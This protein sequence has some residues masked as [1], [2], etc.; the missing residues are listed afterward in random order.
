MENLLYSDENLRDMSGPE[1]DYIPQDMI[2]KVKEIDQLLATTT[3]DTLN[4]HA[5]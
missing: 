1:V 4:Y 3:F 5:L 2:H